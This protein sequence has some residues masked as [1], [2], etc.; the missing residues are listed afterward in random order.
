MPSITGLPPGRNSARLEHVDVSEDG[1]QLFVEI[2]RYLVQADRERVRAAFD[3]A[4]R[5]HGDQRR[6]SGELFFLHPLTVAVYLSKFNLDAPALMA[7]LLHDIAEDTVVSLDDIAAQFGDEVANLVNG[8][9]K[10]KI[11]SESVDGAAEMSPK[12]LADETLHK[13]LRISAGDVRVALIKLF[14]RLHNMRTIQAMPHHKQVQKAEETLAIYAPLANRLGV[15]LLKNELEALSLAVTDPENCDGLRQWLGQNFHDQQLDYDR[16]TQEISGHLTDH[17][18]APAG[19]WSSPESLYSVYQGTVGLASS[20]RNVD[21]TLRLLVL[22]PD[23][24]SCYTALGYIHQLWPP[25]TEFFDDYIAAPRDNLY[26]SLHTTVFYRQRKN[27][28]IRLRTPEMD[29][30]SEI[31]VLARWAYA[32]TKV[33][34]ESIEERMQALFAYISQSGQLNQEDVREEVEHMTDLFKKQMVVFT[35]DNDMI[36]LK[37]G[38]TPLDFAYHIH[39]EVGHSCYRAFVNERLYPLNQPLRGGEQVFIE[40]AKR[41][42]PQR[43]WLNEDLGY[44]AT[45]LA[46]NRILRWF[47]RQPDQQLLAEG[48]ELLDAELRLFN[49]PY[50]HNEVVKL[51]GFANLEALY[52]ALGRAD[53]TPKDIAVTLLKQ[54]WRAEPTLQSGQIVEMAGGQKQMIIG[55]NSYALHLC[56]ICQP[57]P[58]DGIIGFVR[59]RT[60]VTVH[61]EQCRTL[62]P[63]P[64]HER[65][66]KLGWRNVEKEAMRALTVQVDVHDRGGLLL[67]ITA[68]INRLE[69]NISGVWTVRSKANQKQLLLEIEVCSP[70]QFATILH[71]IQALVNVQDV[72]YLPGVSCWPPPRSDA[73]SPYYLPE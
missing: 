32:G 62:S 4:R 30:V 68:L 36:D 66:I 45:A 20:Y 60:A 56:R 44:I 16:L 61:Q 3:L 58:G 8:V 37:V 42:Q 33:W 40:T 5:E 9:T 38:A 6:R 70:E 31:G 73:A 19:I 29:M 71:R 25:R 1:R 14:D 48:K 23:L 50:S 43:I 69:V 59:S 2:D 57:Q 35:P 41:P 27:V 7:A 15:W 17:N 49:M 64:R 63:D 46:R 52:R 10:L 13:L 18:L 65:R 24:A 67:E 55:A 28:K 54:D 34:T 11:L 47:R 21:R 51:C 22:M 39:T 12:Q 72:R 26:Q 53:R